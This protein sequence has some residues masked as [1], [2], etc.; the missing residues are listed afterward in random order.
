MKFLDNITWD[1]LKNEEAIT[2]PSL[3]LQNPGQV[4]VIDSG[5]PQDGGRPEFMPASI[6]PPAELPDADCP[7]VLTTGRKLEHCRTA[8]MIRRPAVLGAVGHVARRDLSHGQVHPRGN[9]G[10]GVCTL[11]LCRSGHTYP[12][13]SR[14]RSLW[15]GCRVQIRSGPGG[16]GARRRVARIT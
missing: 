4:V 12:D 2:H 8:S 5:F 15:E 7:M 6:I 9:G 3:S 14:A 1:Q 13:Q 10:H 16:T 11:C